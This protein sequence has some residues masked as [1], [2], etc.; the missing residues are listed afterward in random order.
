MPAQ[1]QVGA[2]RRSERVDQSH[3]L[4]LVLV[5]RVADDAGRVAVQEG[6]DGGVF[7]VVARAA[8]EV[9]EVD[10]RGRRRCL[11]STAE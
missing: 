2:V 1:V 3:V 10:V 4:V 9:A 7:V 11:C 6:T 5:D 8:V